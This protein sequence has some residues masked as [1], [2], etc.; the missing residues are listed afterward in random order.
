MTMREQ[1]GLPPQAERSIALFVDAA[2]TAFGPGLVSIV[3]FGS[4]AAGSMRATSDVNVIVVLRQFDRDAADRLKEP[5]QVVHAAAELTAMFLLESEIPAAMEAFAVKF[6]DILGRHRVLHGP[7]PFAELATTRDALKRRLAQVLL[8]LQLRLRERYILWGL[9]EDQLALVI[10]D[11]AAPLRSGAATLIRLEG[12]DWDGNAKA[13]LKRIAA[14]EGDSS[15]G[16]ALRNVSVARETGH[17]PVGTAGRTLFGLIGLAA[18][19]RRRL[20]RLAS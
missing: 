20:D 12:G 6:F 17:L 18:A 7:D 5:M 11:S 14:E 19:M 10:A 1:E 15:F 9:R 3:L 8:N 13:A 16:E 2:R 4:A